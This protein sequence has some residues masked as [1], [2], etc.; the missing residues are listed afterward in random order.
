MWTGL[1]RNSYKI[2]DSQRNNLKKNEKNLMK[3][4]DLTLSF[5]DNLNDFSYLKFSNLLNTSNY[6]KSSF[7][8]L[9]Y[10]DNVNSQIRQIQNNKNI[11]AHKLLGAG[12]GGFI[13]CFFKDKKS[14]LNYI[15]QR[16]NI[17]EIQVSKYGS[18]VREFS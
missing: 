5:M 18:I 16:K 3:L 9:I 12:G 1:S 13:L 8:K 15:K 4:N 14:K 6:L 7:S 2:L 11:L 10:N 17:L